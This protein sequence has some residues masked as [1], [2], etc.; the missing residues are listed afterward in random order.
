MKGPKA[1]RDPEKKRESFYIMFEKEI[2][3]GILPNGEV[4]TPIYLDKGR[5]ISSAKIVGGINTQQILDMLKT[6][7]GFCRLVYS[8]GVSVLSQ[9]AEETIGFKFLFYGK[10]D[11][12]KTGTKLQLSV[13]GNGAEILLNLNTAEWKGGEQEPGQIQFL[14]D[15]PGKTAIVNVRFYLQDGFTVPERE[16]QKPVQFGTEAYKSMI[17]SSYMQSGNKYRLKTAIEKAEKGEPVTYPF[18]AASITQGSGAAPITT[19]CYAYK[20]FCYFRDR[21]AKDKEQMTYIKAGVGGTPS[22]LGMIRFE[23]DVLRDGAVSPDIVV[24]E[25]GVNDEGDETQG[26]CF[27]SLVLKILS[28]PSKPAVILLFNVFADDCNLQK[29]LAPIGEH[30]QLPMVSI[31][32]A[33]VEQFRLK[34]EQGR[35]VSKSQYFYDMYHPTNTGHTIIAD[36]IDYL[37]DKIDGELPAAEFSVEGIKPLLGDAF[38][39]VKLFDRK[40]KWNSVMYHCGSFSSVDTVLQCVEMDLN[41]QLTQQLPYNWMRKPENGNEAFVLEGSFKSLILIYKDSA[42]SNVGRAEVFVDGNYAITAD[43]H[44]N[45]WVHCNP[46]IVYQSDKCAFHRVEINMEVGSEDKQFT[47]LGFGY[48]V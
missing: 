39:E 35:I 48:V 14:F 13:P 21:F 42:D 46:A 41:F 32:N 3:A 7:D 29:R 16:M 36:C 25:F 27:E 37:I 15:K 17:A 22:E 45:G 12:E 2:A 5:L 47:I 18:I 11:M 4:G 10:T 40:D 20:A 26:V 24:V 23:R 6:K 34:A 30:Y 8:I 31:L 44:V 19:E 38:K 28:L 43:P 33:V 9:D 1:P